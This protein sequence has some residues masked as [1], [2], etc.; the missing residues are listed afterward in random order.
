MSHQP[1]DNLAFVDTETLGLDPTLHPIWELAVITGGEEYH[2]FIRVDGVDGEFADP[3][4][5][6]KLAA[7]YVQHYDDQVAL[8]AV[9]GIEDLTNGLS[10][11]IWQKI[12][13]LEGGGRTGH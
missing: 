12:A 13:M 2:W 5:L 6:G 11:K 10:R 9:D 1:H 7:L 3:V 8:A 4:A